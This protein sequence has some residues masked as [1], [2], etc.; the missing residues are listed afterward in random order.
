MRV[1]VVPSEVELHPNILD[2]VT[3]NVPL[4]V[5]DNKFDLVAPGITFPFLIH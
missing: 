4:T 2:S 1:M 5:E 3:L